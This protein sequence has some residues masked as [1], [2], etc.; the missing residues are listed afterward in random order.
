[1]DTTKAGLD[2]LNKQLQSE[3]LKNEILTDQMKKLE[4]QTISKD[5]KPN[6]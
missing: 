2:S 1:M 5:S 6:V 4:V 3:R